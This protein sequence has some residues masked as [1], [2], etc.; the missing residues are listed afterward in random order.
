MEKSIEDWLSFC[1]CENFTVKD[2]KFVFGK[3]FDSSKTITLYFTKK[4]KNNV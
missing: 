1:P 2:Q 3:N 4:Q